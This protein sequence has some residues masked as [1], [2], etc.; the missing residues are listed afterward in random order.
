ME[1]KP[2]FPKS[3]QDAIRYF[4]NPDVCVEFLASVR[5]PEGAICPACE[6]KRAT[7]LKSRRIWKCKECGRQFSVKLGTIFEESPIPLDKW[8][9]AVWLVVNCKNGVSS[10]ELAKDL[11][12]TQKSAWFM[13]HR[14]REALRNRSFEKLGGTGGAVESDESFIGANPQKMHKERRLKLQQARS[15]KRHSEVWPGKTA[16]IGMLDRETRKIRTQVIPNVKRETLQ[17]AILDNV[18]YGSTIYTD[19]A[20]AYDNLSKS[21][22]HEVVNHAVEYVNGQVHTNG[23]EN[24]WSLFKRN[25]RGTYV[26][27]EP[28]HLERYLD[29]QVWRFNNRGGKKR[30]E[31]ITDSD[32]FVLAC[33]QITGKRLTFAELT[34]KD[35]QQQEAF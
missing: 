16:V 18:A 28:F 15:I 6:Q 22:V 27:V 24:F 1:S 17:N 23:L 33:S 19:S 5:W 25:L 12:V 10:Y 3:L 21:F 35:G 7:F 31:R 20:V 2:E 11:G 29:E 4:D 13:L 9:T 32:R 8:L 30:D 14:I 34:G 26:S